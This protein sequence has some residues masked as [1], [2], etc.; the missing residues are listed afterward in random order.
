VTI[1]TALA[2]I[3]VVGLSDSKISVVAAIWRTLMK[4]NLKIAL[5][6]ICLPLAC[7]FTGSGREA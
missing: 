5:P 3:F 6:A 2:V 4:F 7:L 1:I